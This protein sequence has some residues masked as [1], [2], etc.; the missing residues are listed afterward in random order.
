MQVEIRIM[1]IYGRVVKTIAHTIFFTGYCSQPIEW[2][3]ASD[4]GKRLSQGIYIYQLTLTDSKGNARQ[5]SGKLMISKN[6]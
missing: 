1:D 3:G 6:Q 2:D 5:K 4:N